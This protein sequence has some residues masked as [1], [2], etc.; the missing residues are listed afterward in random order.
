M[1]GNKT[2]EDAIHTNEDAIRR[3]KQ[4][5]ARMKV[6]LAD[7]YYFTDNKTLSDK[8]AMCFCRMDKLYGHNIEEMYFKN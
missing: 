3:T 6:L 8:E 1:K 5:V 7:M 2:N 4:L